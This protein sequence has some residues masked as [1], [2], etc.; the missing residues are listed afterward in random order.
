[1]GVGGRG[2]GEGGRGEGVG[3]VWGVVVSRVLRV[4]E[5]EVV[6]GSADV[7][8]RSALTSAPLSNVSDR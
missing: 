7:D 1:M 3:C 4:S 5:W 8:Q 6:V 2:R